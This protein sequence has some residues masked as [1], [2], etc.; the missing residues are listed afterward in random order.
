MGGGGGFRAA[1]GSPTTRSLPEMLN[2]GT[3][4]FSLGACRSPG[5]ITNKWSVWI[6]MQHAVFW[7]TSGFIRLQ[8]HIS[9][10]ILRLGEVAHIYSFPGV[11]MW[12]FFFPLL[13]L[14]LLIP[15]LRRLH[16]IQH[17][18]INLGHNYHC[19]TARSIWT[20]DII[21][22]I[23]IQSHQIILGLGLSGGGWGHKTLT[24][25]LNQESTVLKW[26]KTK[27]VDG[28]IGGKAEENCHHS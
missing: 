2:T 19:I 28:R 3:V 17:I 18:N 16:G 20:N 7:I 12:F 23:M 25:Y 22:Q 6:I 26:R 4:L 8:Y 27:T 10:S 15:K 14:N 11:K 1:T 5:T 9:H 24:H 13:L 21:L